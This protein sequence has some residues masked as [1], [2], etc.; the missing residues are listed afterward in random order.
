MLAATV[1]E[2]SAGYASDSDAL[3]RRMA[4]AGPFGLQRM[5][6]Q[7]GRRLS[8]GKH[9]LGFPVR[10]CYLGHVDKNFCKVNLESV[11]T[12]GL[13]L[14]ARAPFLHAELDQEKFIEAQAPA[15]GCQGCF[16][17]RVVYV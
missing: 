12:G 11:P 13:E 3:M 14:P 10:L 4:W 17:F 9:G 7:N 6:D 2:R 15:G 1:G 5:T 16:I 8:T